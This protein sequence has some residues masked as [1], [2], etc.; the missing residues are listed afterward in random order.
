A[1]DSHI[2]TIMACR[3]YG[4][5]FPEAILAGNHIS[6]AVVSKTGGM[7]DPEDFQRALEKMPEDLRT[8]L[9]AA[10]ADQ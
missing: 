7:L 8:K 1:G 9:K 6:S 3:R 5:T 4:L 2:G 10:M